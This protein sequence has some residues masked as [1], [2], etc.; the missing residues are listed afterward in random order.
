MILMVKLNALEI[1]ERFIDDLG[2]SN[3]S[4]KDLKK[5]FKGYFRFQIIHGGMR[6]YNIA[7]TSC[8]VWIPDEKDK[9]I[10]IDS[11]NLLYDWNTALDVVKDVLK[12]ENK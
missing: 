12:V 8:Y 7:K 2:Y 11:L 5:N 4:Y 10:A 9:K 1:L 6:G 3:L